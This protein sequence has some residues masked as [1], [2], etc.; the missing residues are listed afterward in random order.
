M[1][2][3]RVLAMV[4]ALG[5]PGVLHHADAADRGVTITPLPESFGRYFALVIGI[6]AYQ[7]WNRLQTAV[8]DA[9]QLK[10]ILTERYDFDETNVVLLTDAQATRSAILSHLRDFCGRLTDRDNLLIYFAGHGQVDDLTGDGY[11]IP[12]EG[13]LKDPS[14]WVD[15][16]A[17]KNILTS[18]KVRLKNVVLIADSC[19]SGTL[20][21]AGPSLLSVEDS[22]YR[23]KLLRTAALRSRQVITSGGLE[24]VT[25]G[26]RDGHSLFA[27]YLLKALKE[28]SAE[29]IDIENLFL[30]MV[31][32]AVADIGGQR[33]NVGRMKSPMDEDGQFVLR[34]KAGLA[35]K[36]AAEQLHRQRLAE[37]QQRMETEKQL[38]AAKEAQ[39]RLLIAEQQ[40]IEVEKQQLALQKQQIEEMKTLLAEKQRLERE[41]QELQR[42]QEQKEKLEELRRQNEALQAQVKTAAQPQPA[43]PA[44]AKMIAAVSPQATRPALTL[45]TAPLDSVPASQIDLILKPVIAEHGF[46]ESRINPGGS[47]TGH[48]IDHQNGTV[49]DLRTNLMWQ[50]Q[51]NDKS[52]NPTFQYSQAISYRNAV[53]RQALAGH[54]DWRIPT[55][56]E[57]ASLVMATSTEEGLHQ[58]PVFTP[59]A[60]VVSADTYLPKAAVGSDYH[61]VM[62]FKN[63]KIRYI[64]HRDEQP[65]LSAVRLVRSAGPTTR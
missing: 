21:R 12:V 17:I 25:D 47:F 45:R 27:Y 58:D 20:L 30:S 34:E 39:Q 9:S 53:N 41:K 56:E 54:T 31:W 22:Q 46:F 52:F 4:L 7:A 13:K 8:N 32:A 28:N 48:L 55:I 5:W 18:D 35:A 50:N 65:G 38:L 6:N 61:L 49:S 37:E 16:A 36:K 24:P 42:L 60:F 26:G 29:I 63:G 59:I 51:S 33:P 10:Q 43:P 15:H 1:K 64:L 2:T 11:W 44:P 3:M 14:T 57:L 23:E 62:D 19:Y 40:R